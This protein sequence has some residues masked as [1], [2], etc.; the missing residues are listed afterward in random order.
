MTHFA[1][2]FIPEPHQEHGRREDPEGMP[3]AVCSGSSKARAAGLSGALDAK[4]T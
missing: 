4:T 3:A 2:E 1:A